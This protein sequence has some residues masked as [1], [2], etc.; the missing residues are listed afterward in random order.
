MGF[1]R[2]GLLVI[3][4]I[5]LFLSFLAM[6]S[7]A[8]LNSSLKYENVQEQIAPIVE[9]I[10]SGAIT[11]LIPEE[12][13]D[14][15]GDFNLTK[16]M[17]A[18]KEAMRPYC[19]NVSEYEYVFQEGGFTFTVPCDLL[20]E[21]PET[22]IQKGIEDIVEDTYYSE[23]DCGFWDCIEKT[24]SPL[25]LFSEQAQEYWK[26]KFYYA[27]VVSLILIALM[28]FLVKTKPNWP[29]ITGALLIGS[30]IPIKS[31]EKILTSVVG[32]PFDALVGI[33]FSRASA[34][35]W[36][37]LIIGLLV[38]GGGIAWRV[39]AKDSIKK[40]MSKKD[41]KKLVKEKK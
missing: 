24:G 22:L 4:C 17:E 39:L 20:N 16:E 21:T 34:V 5:L 8:T 6:N 38:L 32:S 40:R 9:N 15:I 13:Q 28:F 18:A 14:S 7:F 31:L 11:D 25:F 37:S 1:F 2:G 29:I 10:T 19:E 23:Y 33:F 36:T 41:V 26:G 35:F 27:L 30:V 3:I 12:F